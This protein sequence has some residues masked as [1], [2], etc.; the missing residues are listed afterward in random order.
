MTASNADFHDDAASSSGGDA[1][2]LLHWASAAHAFEISQLHGAIFE[3]GWTEAD[4]LNLLQHP[5]SLALVAGGG[6][7]S[8]LNGFLLAQ[9]AAD[10]AEILTLGTCPTDQR[11]GIGKR[12][13]EAIKRAAADAGAAA[14]LLEVAEDNAAACRLYQR[15]GFVEAGRRKGYYL[16]RG[17]APR[18][19]LI[20]RCE[21]RRS[22]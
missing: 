6:P 21:L 16:R 9:V 7:S 20:M 12:L 2:V 11:K 4:I 13:V 17:A 5:A 19:A 3:D 18:D 15:C 8:G 10:E 14:I 1:G 22:A